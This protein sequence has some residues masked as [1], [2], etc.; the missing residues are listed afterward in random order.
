MAASAQSDEGEVA[1]V[2]PEGGEG[3]VIE[4]IGQDFIL[5]AVTIVDDELAWHFGAFV[6]LF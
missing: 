3:G 5:D 4:V 2:S 1:Q 6:G